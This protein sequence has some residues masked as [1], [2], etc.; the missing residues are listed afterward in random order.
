MA[1]EKRKGKA[2]FY[3]SERVDDRVRKKYYGRGLSG[4]AQSLLAMREEKRK[5]EERQQVSE[6]QE[7]VELGI[8]TPV[9]SLALMMRFA[10]QGQDEFGAKLLAKMRQGFGG[11]SVPTQGG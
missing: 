1:W 2:Y 11:H 10:S 7:A 4:M 3:E 8:P 6:F 5:R 9:M